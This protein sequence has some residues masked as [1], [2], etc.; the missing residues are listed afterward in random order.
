MSARITTLREVLRWG[1]Q[2]TLVLSHLSGSLGQNRCPTGKRCR[3][4]LERL[5]FSWSLS[6]H[7]SVHLDALNKMISSNSSKRN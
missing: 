3:K 4:M 6:L 1:M 2:D 7:E 5:G